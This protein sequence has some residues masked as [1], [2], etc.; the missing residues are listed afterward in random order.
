MERVLVSACLL[1]SHVRY[2]GSYRL[3]DHPVLTRWQAEGPGRAN[4]SR[5]CRRFLHAASC[6]RKFM[7]QGDAVLRGQGRG[8]R[9]DGQAM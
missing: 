1:G 3:N 2:N 7:A 6:R 8:G 9:A 5:G 4:L